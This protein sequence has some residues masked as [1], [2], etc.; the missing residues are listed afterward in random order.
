M[1]L[2]QG[3][4]E[5]YQRQKSQK[6]KRAKQIYKELARAYRRLKKR[7]YIGIIK[8]TLVPYFDP[9]DGEFITMLT[10][11]TTIHIHPHYY[12]GIFMGYVIYADDSLLEGFDTFRQA[13]RFVKYL[14]SSC[15]GDDE[16]I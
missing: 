1:K 8:E 12:D 15:N 3:L 10:P 14:K 2:W 4:K 6:N 11:K 9:F 13:K 5:S 7:Q 16:F